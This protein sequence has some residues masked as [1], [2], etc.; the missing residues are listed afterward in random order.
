MKVM[1]CHPHYPSQ[2]KDQLMLTL[3]L[4]TCI[5]GLDKTLRDVYCDVL[6]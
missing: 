6:I 3:S 4:Q 5:S 2:E 1:E